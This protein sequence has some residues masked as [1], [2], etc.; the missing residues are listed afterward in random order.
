MGGRYKP[1]EPTVYSAILV[2]II[3]Q[4]VVLTADLATLMIQSRIPN[5]ALSAWCTGLHARLTG[6]LQLEKY[7]D[8]V[9]PVPVTSIFT[10]SFTDFPNGRHFLAIKSSY[11]KNHE[12]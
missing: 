3:T 1:G 9:W 12:I 11:H 4:N 5:L 10:I 8:V 6:R 7:F 2:S